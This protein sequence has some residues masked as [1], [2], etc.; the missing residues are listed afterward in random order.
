MYGTENK[1]FLGVYLKGAKKSIQHNFFQDNFQSVHA[2][3]NAENPIK[4]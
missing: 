4:C 3:K 1:F 2:T